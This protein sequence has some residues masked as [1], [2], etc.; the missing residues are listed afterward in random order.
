MGKEE[1]KYEK[2]SDDEVEELIKERLSE[3]KE[4]LR[5]ILEILREASEA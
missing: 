4:L 3:M 2:L 5:E 1:L